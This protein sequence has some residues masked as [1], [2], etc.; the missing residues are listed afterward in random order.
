M[1]LEQEDT[2]KKQSSPQL[3]EDIVYASME[4]GE[5]HGVPTRTNGRMT[6]QLS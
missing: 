4:I 5:Y 6:E 3:D 1:A 2:Q